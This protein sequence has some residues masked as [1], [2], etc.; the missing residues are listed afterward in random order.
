[1]PTAGT[2][3][4]NAFTVSTTLG[5]HVNAITSD[6][7]TII[8]GLI[9]SG[10][11]VVCLMSNYH[12]YLG[13]EPS[14]G[15]DYTKVRCYYSEYSGTSRDPE[16]RLTYTDA[17]TSSIYST[18]TGNDDDGYISNSNFD[19]TKTWVEIRG[20]ETTSGSFRNVAL[21]NSA[22]AIYARRFAARGAVI[23][24]CT[25]SYF[26]FDL[27]GESGTVASSTIHFYLDNFGTSTG[28]S[29]NIIAV[30]A[31]TLAG[32]TT[33]FGNCYVADAVTVT[34]NATFFGA[35]F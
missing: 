4:A 18:S 9:G 31:T 24:D 29:A 19:D 35:N 11:L 26:V 3:L 8:N 28:D 27:S 2:T 1:M 12:D 17:S 5:T 16:L 32:D 7:I 30:Q 15:G 20:D 33:D 14:E 13:N 21:N 22:V 6:G 25:R 34:H 10:K 23:R